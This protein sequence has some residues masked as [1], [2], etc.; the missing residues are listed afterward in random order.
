MASLQPARPPSGSTDGS[1]ESPEPPK[2]AV[3]PSKHHQQQQEEEGDGD[4]VKGESEDEA[5][6]SPDRLSKRMSNTPS[7]DN[8]D[9]NDE[10]ATKPKGQ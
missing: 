6:T 2:D 8:I 10:A 3:E 5:P 9:L 1:S 7:L 4:T